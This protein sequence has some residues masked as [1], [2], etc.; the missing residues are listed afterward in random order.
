SIGEGV[1]WQH[2]HPNSF[3]DVSACKRGEERKGM[4]RDLDEA[5]QLARE[6][7]R[8]IREHTGVTASAGVS[9]NKFLAKLASDAHK[10]DG[11][12]VISAEDAPAF[13]DALPID[14]FSCVGKV[15]AAKLQE[16]GIETGPISNAWGK[17]LYVP[18]WESM[19]GDCITLSVARM[20]DRSNPR[21][22]ASR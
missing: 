2:V 20:T 4:H 12:T 8:Q 5:A 19:G 6:I 1:S 17:R 3:L 10:L 7:K 11:F 21:E 9:Y 22:N 15:A 14:H 18:C 13:L 16:V